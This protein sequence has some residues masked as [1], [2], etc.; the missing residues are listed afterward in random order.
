MGVACCLFHLNDLFGCY[1]LFHFFA[2]ALGAAII[3][4]SGYR[5]RVTDNE[6][7]SRLLEAQEGVIRNCGGASNTS[8]I[9][10]EERISPH[11]L[12]PQQQ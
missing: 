10:L 11:H 1:V 4:I 7:T 12:L 6:M 3:A 2:T 9:T 5:G 8:S